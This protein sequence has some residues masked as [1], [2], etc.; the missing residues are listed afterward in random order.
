MTKKAAVVVKDLNFSYR[1]KHPTL[2]DVSFTVFEGDFIGI[3]GPNGGG[4][5]TLLKLLMGFLEPDSGMIEIFGKSPQSY[6]NGI[7]YVPQTL[8]FDKSFPLTVLELVLEGRLS[9]LSW[10]GRFSK[11]DRKQALETL[12]HVGLASLHN[13]PFGT[14]SGGELQR[15]LIARALVQQPQI[16]LLDEPTAHVDTEGETEI[17]EILNSIRK[18]LTI[19]MVTHDIRAIVSQVTEVICVQGRVSHIPVRELCEHFAMGLYHFPL[20]Q[21][22]ITHLKS[23]RR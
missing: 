16:L 7:A 2:I 22:P 12:E 5:T 11:N 8:R 17:Y 10:N 21:T 18:R 15:A 13:A 1:N 14:L 19:L 20:I 6:P 23:Q 9:K 3:I 4:K